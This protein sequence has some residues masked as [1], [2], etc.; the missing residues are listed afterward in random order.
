MEGF[1]TA[2]TGLIDV[3]AMRKAVEATPDTP[4]PVIRKTQ[5]APKPEP[6]SEEQPEWRIPWSQQVSFRF[7][8]SPLKDALR[9]VARVN[10]LNMVIGD[11]VVG[12]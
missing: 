10:Q 6:V 1:F 3:D 11:G 8:D 7:N 9:T 2:V 5:V 4:K 12:R